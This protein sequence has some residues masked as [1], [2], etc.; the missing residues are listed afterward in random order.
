MK[1]RLEQ[2]FLEILKDFCRAVLLMVITEMIKY[3]LEENHHKI[4]R[5]LYSKFD[6]SKMK[7]IV[8]KNLKCS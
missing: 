3:K 6:K 8:K 2:Q 4:A 5:Q 1:G 7:C